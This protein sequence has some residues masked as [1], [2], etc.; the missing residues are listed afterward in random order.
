MKPILV[1]TCTNTYT[2]Q[3]QQEDSYQADN[4][5]AIGHTFDDDFVEIVVTNHTLLLIIKGDKR[6]VKTIF[7]LAPIVVLDLGT[8]SR[9]VQKEGIA[10]LAFGHNLLVGGNHVI[11][12][13]GFVLAVVHENVDVL[14]L[15]AVHILDVGFL[16]CVQNQNGSD[17]IGENVRQDVSI[18]ETRRPGK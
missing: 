13:R 14:L 12:S 7:F 16:K 2:D 17:H 1:P 5:D 3:I 9:I 4:V 6:L 18:R 15:E 11:L 8:M 10:R